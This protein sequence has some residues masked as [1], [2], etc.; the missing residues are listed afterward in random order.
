MKMKDKW[1]RDRET[2]RRRDRKT[3]GQK[4]REEKIYLKR[5][6]DQQGQTETE[7]D[8]VEASLAD[9]EKYFFCFNMT[10]NFDN[11]D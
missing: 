9:G 7:R 6:T 4:E 1:Q 5:E 3:E 11:C 10:F 8:R 2:E